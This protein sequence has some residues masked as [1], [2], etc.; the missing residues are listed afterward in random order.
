MSRELKFD[1]IYKG[2]TGFHHKKYFLET[3]MCGIKSICD[4]HEMMELIATRQYTGL[5]D[6]N[7]A[8]IYEGDILEHIGSGECA[9]Q[10]NPYGGPIRSYK[11]Q[12]F[13]V[14]SGAGGFL[15]RH[16]EGFVP[17]KNQA[18]NLI[19]GGWKIIEPYDLWNHQRWNVVIGNIHENPELL[20]V[21]S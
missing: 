9:I 18:P 5:K 2:E 7:S 1:L 10:S 8:E 21:K 14:V 12:R 16:V 17:G 6:K 11:G 15:G 3:L 20:E 4:I 13:V 19:A